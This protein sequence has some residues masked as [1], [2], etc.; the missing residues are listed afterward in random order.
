V[1]GAAL[2][3]RLGRGGLA[4]AAPGAGAEVLVVPLTRGG[5]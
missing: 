3:A 2:V 5:R 1:D 4:D